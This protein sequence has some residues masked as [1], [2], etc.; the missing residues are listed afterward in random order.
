ML[1]HDIWSMII[2]AFYSWRIVIVA[3][4]FS[5]SNDLIWIIFSYTITPYSNL[6]HCNGIHINVFRIVMVNVNNIVIVDLIGIIR[7]VYCFFCKVN[8]IIMLIRWCVSIWI[9]GHSSA[10]LIYLFLAELVDLFGWANYTFANNLSWRMRK[11]Q[12]II[13]YI[14]SIFIYFCF[15]WVF[16]I[17]RIINNMAINIGVIVATIPN[18]IF[19]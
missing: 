6:I 9:K 18:N 4:D 1:I 2:S 14:V 7:L 15:A 12:I 8:V 5:I 16:I 13:N 17:F 10:F 3:N 11:I 19:L